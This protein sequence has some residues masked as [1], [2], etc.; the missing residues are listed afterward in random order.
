MLFT[1]VADIVLFAAT[2]SIAVVDAAVALAAMSVAVL[3]QYAND[4]AAVAA[5][6]QQLFQIACDQTETL[7]LWSVQH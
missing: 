3:A 1:A 6:V 5:V 4:A 2:F 7:N